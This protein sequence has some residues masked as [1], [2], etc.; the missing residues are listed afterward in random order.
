[1]S[2]KQDYIII[3]KPTATTTK[4]LYSNTYSKQSLEI[5]KLTVG[6]LLSQLLL[7]ILN[8][9]VFDNFYNN[10]VLLVILI[11][12]FAVSIYLVGTELFTYIKIQNDKEQLL[13]DLSR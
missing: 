9:A 12:V 4:E 5:L 3:N 7:K 1:M 11:I 13:K 6:F 2:S 8:E 10:K